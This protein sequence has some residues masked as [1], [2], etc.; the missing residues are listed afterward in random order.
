M[1]TRCMLC[2]YNRALTTPFST[3]IYHVMA[4]WYCTSQNP[5]SPAQ[6]PRHY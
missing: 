5:Q 1:M 6:N 4:G 2:S 3:K